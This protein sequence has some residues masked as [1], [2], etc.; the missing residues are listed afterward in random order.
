MSTTI[1]V[2]Y[3]VLFLI[4]IAN[5]GMVGKI[6]DDNKCKDGISKHGINSLLAGAMIQT[7]FLFIMALV[8]LYHPNSST[9]LYILYAFF[10]LGIIL[11]FIGIG[12][13]NEKNF[14]AENKLLQGIL[15]MNIVH[16]VGFIVSLIIY[17]YLSNTSS[18]PPTSPQSDTLSV[19]PPQ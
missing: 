12:L 1:K 8:T 16:C 18:T 5:L 2:Q 10:A 9:L 11:E 13:L 4:S 7:F 14:L 15:G 19:L 17:R 3:W 6:F